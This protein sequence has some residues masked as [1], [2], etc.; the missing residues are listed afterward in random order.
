MCPFS[1]ICR[2]LCPW[3]Q[4]FLQMIVHSLGC[5]HCGCVCYQNKSYCAWIWRVLGH[6]TSL[7]RHTLRRALRTSWTCHCRHLT[8][9]MSWGRVCTVMFL[10]MPW[11]QKCLPN[12]LWLTLWQ[13]VC[14]MYPVQT[15]MLGLIFVTSVMCTAMPLC[16]DPAPA[17]IRRNIQLQEQLDESCMKMMNFRGWKVHWKMVPLELMRFH[18]LPPPS[19]PWHNTPAILIEQD[20]RLVAVRHRLVNRLRTDPLGGLGLLKLLMCVMLVVSKL[21]VQRLINRDVC[22]SLESSPPICG[23][24]F[25]G[26]GRVPR[27]RR[28]TM[29]DRSIQ[30]EPVPLSPL[31]PLARPKHRRQGTDKVRLKPWTR[32]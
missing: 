25:A 32:Q 18:L 28:P 19:G 7:L 13:R 17:Q 30:T 29:M 31:R 12:C 2:V 27:K 16:S 9:C 15:V 20:I 1:F 3:L 10:Y 4:R 22:V 14:S 24:A 26:H 21:W 23:E 11:M 5:Q 6:R 8:R